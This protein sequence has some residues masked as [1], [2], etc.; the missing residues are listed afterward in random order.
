M[1]SQTKTEYR[2]TK[3]YTIRIPTS[4]SPSTFCIRD[5]TKYGI[6]SVH[7]DYWEGDEIPDTRGQIGSAVRMNDTAINGLYIFK[8]YESLR[9][10]FTIVLRTVN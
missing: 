5:T 3:V 10:S 9:D 8:Y 6:D 1:P 4:V 2:L 7:W